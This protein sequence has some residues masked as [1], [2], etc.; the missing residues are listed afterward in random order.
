MRLHSAPHLVRNLHGTKLSG[1]HLPELGTDVGEILLSVREREQVLGK[2]SWVRFAGRRLPK[3]KDRQSQ[4]DQSQVSQCC[5]H[6]THPKGALSAKHRFT[7]G[8]APP[9]VAQTKK[10]KI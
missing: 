5:L 2:L 9:C 4:R 10:P 1:N 8:A 6:A 7:C 3:A